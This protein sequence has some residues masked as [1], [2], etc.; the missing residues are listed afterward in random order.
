ME[1]CSSSAAV[2]L[3]VHYW[4]DWPSL[5]Q[6]FAL[7]IAQLRAD[8]DPLVWIASSLLALIPGTFAIHKWWNYRNSRLPQRLLEL[9]ERE[10][11]RLPP[12]RDRLL[13]AKTR[14]YGPI[15]EPLFV[16]PAIGEMVAELNWSRWWYPFT[17]TIAEARV[18]KAL[19]QI[20]SQ[21]IFCNKKFKAYQ[22]QQQL[23]FLLKGSIAAAKGAELSRTDAERDRLNRRALLYFMSALDF[24]RSDLDALGYVGHQQRVIGELDSALETY[25]DLLDSAK[26][27]ESGHALR[28]AHAH[29]AMAEIYEQQF[30]KTK[31]QQRLVDAKLHLQSAADGTPDANRCEVDYAMIYEA[32]GRVELQ[33]RKSITAPEKAFQKGLAIY[34]DILRYRPLDG[35]AVAG[36]RR[37][38][39]YLSSVEAY[40]A[41]M[42][43]ATD[44]AT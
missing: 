1:C 12:V 16:A 6:S 25:K 5:W 31:I 8:V 30:N 27:D 28:R 42:S 32:L 26:A 15:P 38:I 2:V 34:E 19:Q 4:N 41:A 13:N 35:D 7:S 24:E 3:S 10:D 18:D 17:F 44:G 37:M 20:S 9:L 11:R 23:A 33:R 22:R 21:I 14:S 43:Q 39:D 29:R 36:Q 40:R